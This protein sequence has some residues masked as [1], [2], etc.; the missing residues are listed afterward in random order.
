[1]SA[2]RKRGRNSRGNC[3]DIASLIRAAP[4]KAW[5]LA[6]I[7]DPK[8]A[9]GPLTIHS[10]VDFLAVNFRTGLVYDA[11]VQIGV[12]H[13]WMAAK[14]LRQMPA[15]LDRSRDT[16]KLQASPVPYWNAI[17]QIEIIGSHE[18]S[19]RS[20]APIAFCHDATTGYLISVNLH[21]SEARFS[22]PALARSGGVYDQE[23][24]RLPR[25]SPGQHPKRDGFR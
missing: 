16:G 13:A 22:A 8:R 10:R 9:P 3:P 24:G 2:S 23:K 12:V 17:F 11:D 18:Q 21:L 6:S 20:G 14:L 1:M 25:P 7:Q 19:R 15:M 4:G 5:F